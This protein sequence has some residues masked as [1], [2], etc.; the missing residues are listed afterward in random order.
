VLSIF[1]RNINYRKLYAEVADEVLYHIL[2][3][4]NLVYGSSVSVW[5]CN[6]DHTVEE[7]YNRSLLEKGKEG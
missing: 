4:K 3:G 5:C 6:D 2:L 1:F 7:E